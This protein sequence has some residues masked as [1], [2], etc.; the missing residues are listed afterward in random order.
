MEEQLA[1]LDQEWEREAIASRELVEEQK[2]VMFEARQSALAEMQAKL[3][4]R[5][6]HMNE[7]VDAE[8]RRCE[9]VRRRELQKAEDH[10]QE[11]HRCKRHISELSS[12]YRR[13][14][15]RCPAAS[16]PRCD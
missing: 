7:Q 3:E 2:Q 8:R 1:K 13:R 9:I 12:L 16:T 11:V 10:Q 6:R 5:K 14:R 4:A 15:Y